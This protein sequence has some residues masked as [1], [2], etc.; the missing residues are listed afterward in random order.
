MPTDV[1]ADATA[2]PDRRARRRQETIAEILDLAET[3]MLEEG[4]NG[5]SIS[6]VARRL[7]V[8]PPSI[9]KYFPSLLAVYDAL[10]ERGQLAHL[11]VMRAAMADASP[12][13][14]ALTKGLEASGRWLLANRA[15]AQLL[16]WRP[17]PSFEPSA[18]AMA[19][20]VEM[21]AM[22]RQALADA[23]R[24]NEL[25]PDADSDEAVFLVS[26]LITGVLSQ[27]FANEPDLPWGEG[28]FTSVFPKLMQLLP[29]AYPPRA[30]PRRR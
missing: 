22:Q 7:G 23:A 24:A 21:V 12:G 29:A 28:R 30:K 1:T 6:E 10:F 27:A 13:L 16:F 3:V 25:G 5:L 26:T 19:S 20:S 2:A 15:L 11:E 9:Y 17:V 14:D 8:Q 18:R 4:V